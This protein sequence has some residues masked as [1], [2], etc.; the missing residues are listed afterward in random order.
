MNF[1]KVVKG[2]ITDEGHP[3]HLKGV[4]LGGWLM[5]EGYI[6]YAPNRGYRFFRERFIKARGE[7]AFRDLQ[8]AFRDNFI[9]EDDFK[10]IAALGFDHVRVPFHYALIETEP[11]LYS[12]EGIK[13]LERAVRW[14]KKHGLR[15]IL[16]MHSV[17][18]AQNHDWH[19]NSDG[20]ALFWQV[21][22]YRKRA[23]ALW[24][25]LAAHFYNEPAVIGYDIL[26]EAV[27]NDPGLLNAYYK[28]AVKAIRS[29]NNKHIIFTEGNHW[30]QDIECLDESEDDNLVLG[31]HF[32]EP[33]EFTFNFIPGLIY[34][35]KGPKLTWDKGFMRQR[36]E[37]FVRSSAG[38]GRAL[39]CGEF[40][41][42]SRSGKYG[43]DRWV[44]DILS[45][46][47]ALDIHWTY[48]TWKAIKHHMFPDGVM[49][50]YPND[51]WINRPGPVTGWDTWAQ[52]WPSKEKEM[53]ASWRTA[54]FSANEELVQIFKQNL[55]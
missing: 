10:R 21:P 29:V 36:L 12:N 18:G 47:K 16:D 35:L 37:S 19:S 28:E 43:E 31:I 26:N 55:I 48:W 45:H 15:V 39:W 30:A 42:Q 4:N 7:A 20:R 52:Y 5:P 51:P 54:A 23:A 17:P 6:M 9:T 33:L 46:F 40:G 38:R 49:S 32:Y 8:K 3:V 24:Q 25:M 13:Y 41:V 44:A 2:R 11:Y 1:L 14:A 50:Y 22:S 34:P 27:T 53:I